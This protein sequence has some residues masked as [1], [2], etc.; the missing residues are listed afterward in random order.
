MAL[1]AAGA[2]DRAVT[3]CRSQLKKPPFVAAVAID[4]QLKIDFS[5]VG[6]AGGVAVK[7]VII[8]P[9]A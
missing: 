8:K 4:S 2:G 9:V 1:G 7:T 5:C 6:A 3:D